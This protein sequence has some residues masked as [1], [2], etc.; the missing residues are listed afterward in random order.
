MN[1]EYNAQKYLSSIGLEGSTLVDLLIQRAAKQ[2]DR[3][4]YRFLEDGEEESA[5]WDYQ[6]LLAR[7][8]G[9]ALELQARGLAGE[10]VIL[11]YPPGL[12]YIAAFLGC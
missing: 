2:P 11:L 9:I 8:M 5:V 12:E 3:V 10:R 4:A 7:S 1:A 6:T